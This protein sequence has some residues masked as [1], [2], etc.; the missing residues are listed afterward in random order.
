MQA[1]AGTVAGGPHIQGL[2]QEA[3]KNPA[4]AAHIEKTKADA[5]KGFSGMGVRIWSLKPT[6]I[7]DIENSAFDGV[8]KIERKLAGPE[9]EKISAGDSGEVPP[10]AAE[11]QDDGNYSYHFEGK[12]TAIPSLTIY[13]PKQDQPNQNNSTETPKKSGWRSWLPKVLLFGGIA[14]AIAGFFFPPLL[15]LGGALMSGYGMWKLMGGEG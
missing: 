1:V 5:G 9:A 10:S 6:R 7:I 2:R 8:P 15:F 14:A 11:E 3:A 4:T 12:R 13:T